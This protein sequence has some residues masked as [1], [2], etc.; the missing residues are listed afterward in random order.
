ME[1]GLLTIFLFMS[2][3]KR[4]RLISKYLILI[5]FKSST[6]RCN[7]YIYFG[8]MVNFSLR[9][10]WGNPKGESICDKQEYFYSKNSSIFIIIL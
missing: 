9:R 2:L 8:R 6:F 3:K 7:L 5:R 10:K 1:K 4:V